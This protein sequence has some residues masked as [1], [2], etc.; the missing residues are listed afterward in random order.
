MK[1]ENTVVLHEDEYSNNREIITAS[2]IF[3]GV[4]NCVGS[5]KRTFNITMKQSTDSKPQPDTP[6]KP[7]TGEIST[8]QPDTPTN[9]ST[10]GGYGM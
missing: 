5:I 8:T 1:A 3:N 2:V 7:N 10:G 4:W 9:P 6:T